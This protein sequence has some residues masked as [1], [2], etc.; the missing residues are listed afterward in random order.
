MQRSV[1]ATFVFIF[2]FV[3]LVSAQTSV[4]TSSDLWDAVN[5]AVPGTEIIVENGGSSLCDFHSSSFHSQAP[6]PRSNPGDLG[7]ER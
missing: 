3:A 7:L 2:A 1:F 5:S 4:S 6:I